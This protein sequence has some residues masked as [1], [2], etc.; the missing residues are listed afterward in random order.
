MPEVQ[1]LLDVM[2]EKRFSDPESVIEAGR[3]LLSHAEAMGDVALRGYAEFS[4]GDAFYTL[5]DTE[6]CMFY[7]KLAIKSLYDSQDWE[8]L[9]EC[10]NLIGIL[11]SHQGN[12]SNSL[13]SY[14]A[15]IE[16]AEKH[17]LNYLSGLVYENFSEL[18]SRAGN[19][20][21][22][23][24]NGMLSKA[25]LEKCTDIPRA[26]N[27]T[28]ATLV[29][30][31][32]IS[33]KLG[34]YEQTER[35]MEEMEKYLAILPGEAGNFDI[36]LL[37]LLV[38]EFFHDEAEQEY[39]KKTYQSFI[40]C[41]YMIDFF[42]DC[43]DFMAYL[44]KTGH[45]DLLENVIQ[46]LE[47]SMQEEAV[48]DMSLHV[49]RFKIN[50]LKR[51]GRKEELTAQLDHFFRLSNLQNKQT[52]EAIQMIIEMKKTLQSSKKT[53][54]LLTR[55]SCTDELTSI[56]NRRKLNEET[57]R[58]FENASRE[59]VN[60]GVEMMDIDHFKL[61]N[62]TYGHAMGDKILIA[63]STVLRSIR[64]D[65]IF[66]A[67]YGGDEFFILYYDF[68]DDTI[69]EISREIQEKLEETC[70]QNDLPVI[71]ISQ[72]ICNRIPKELNKVWDYTSIADQA[73]Y[74]IKKSGGN[75]TLIAHN[76]KKL[77]KMLI[78]LKAAGQIHSRN[79]A[80]DV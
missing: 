62:D 46:Q 78:E 38:A 40:Q 71:T 57:D 54:L 15:A 29:S 21:E 80:Q 19:F 14:Y 11:F 23:L 17:H 75:S 73:L 65:K 41:P 52:E 77:K 66:C 31:A 76:A 2:K 5:S 16:L 30:L 35:M 47:K 24:K 44:E 7:L 26:K 60:L 79:F 6:N 39:L 12:A 28:L 25:Y 50:L 45:D 13:D 9:G 67:R 32:K 27:L 61:V 55:L 42:W 33:L 4:I 3:K 72:G 56:P 49:L 18:C 48:P 8:M 36:M 59:Q 43:V 1:K 69:L 74:V 51:Q 64:N 68:D 58:M 10:Y 53:N 70:R 22:A 37:R 20:E 34:R 63:L